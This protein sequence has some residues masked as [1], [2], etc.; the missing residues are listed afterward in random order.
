[1]RYGKTKKEAIERGDRYYFTGR[2]CPQSHV[3][4][5][6]INGSCVEC[7][8]LSS[9]LKRQS[10]QGEVLRK[11]RRQWRADNPEASKLIG[12]KRRLRNPIKYKLGMARH[13][14]KILG[15]AFDL[16]ESDIIIPKKC[17]I[18]GIELRLSNRPRDPYSP[19]IDR[20][21]NDKG[22]TKDN[23]VIISNRANAIKGDATMEELKAIVN[24]YEK[25]RPEGWRPPDLSDLVDTQAVA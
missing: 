23:I 11:K 8:K 7:K 22:Y 2:P 19:S 9:R 4:L 1:M 15:V 10:D 16:E 13:R 20:I 3:G 25:L 21:D 14:A 24:F 18:L 5:R 17:P 12:K 6:A